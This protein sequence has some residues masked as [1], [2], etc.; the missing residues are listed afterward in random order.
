MDPHGGKVL[1]AFRLEAHGR[2]PAHRETPAETVASRSLADQAHSTVGSEQALASQGHEAV[3]E[4]RIETRARRAVQQR[5]GCSMLPQLLYA[6]RR[7]APWCVSTSI[8]RRVR[9]RV[10][11][12]GGTSCNAKSR[13]CRMLSESAARHARR[14]CAD[15]G[16]P[17][18]FK[19]S[20]PSP[21]DAVRDGSAKLGHPVQNVT[22]EHGLTPLPR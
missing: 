19:P 3:P 7:V 12:S 14:W 16:R 10:E 6:A 1:P 5:V 20:S 9:D 17:T 2:R 18:R 11:W 13:N 15:A 21:T 8:S 4:L 22:R